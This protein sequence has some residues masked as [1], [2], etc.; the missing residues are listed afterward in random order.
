MASTN[1]MKSVTQKESNDSRSEDDHHHHQDSEQELL[2]SIELFTD[3]ESLLRQINH[4]LAIDQRD[5]QTKVSAQLAQKEAAERERTRLRGKNK[6]LFSHF[7]C[8]Q[9]SA[10]II[11]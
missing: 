11:I 6:K 10:N 1:E 2:S 7:S 8:I 9:A 4:L 3:I 5:D